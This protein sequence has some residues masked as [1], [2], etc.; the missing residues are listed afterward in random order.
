[1]GEGRDVVRKAGT[2]MVWKEAA[3]VKARTARR[4][5]EGRQTAERKHE[6]GRCLGAERAKAPQLP[7]NAA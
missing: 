1:L 2:E 6:A 3:R 7:T 4:G 5:Q